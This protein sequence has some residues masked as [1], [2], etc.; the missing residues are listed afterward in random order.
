MAIRLTAYQLA[1]NRETEAVKGG[2]RETEDPQ[3]GIAKS[4]TL[5]ITS[6]CAPVGQIL[7]RMRG[8]EL[9]G[10]ITHSWETLPNQG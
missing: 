6:V 4:P 8:W 3:R 9:A 2:G 5:C 1:L 7:V 10:T